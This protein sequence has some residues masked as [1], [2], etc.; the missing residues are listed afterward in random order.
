MLEIKGLRLPKRV[1]ATQG[2]EKAKI[3]ITLYGSSLHTAG[4]GTEEGIVNEG[5]PPRVR[6]LCPQYVA[7]MAASCT[8]DRGG[9]LGLL[10]QEAGRGE[11]DGG[12][13]SQSEPKAA[14]DDGAS[15]P[16]P[17][18]AKPPAF[19][20]PAVPQKP[21]E[22]AGQKGRQEER[23]LVLPAHRRGVGSTRSMP[24]A[25]AGNRVTRELE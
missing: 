19:Q 4:F 21:Q 24:S 11:G 9:S 22:K 18:A 25:E 13:G 6:T 23:R 1:T 8:R 2:G 16:A 20:R 7:P 17:A 14:E 15:L 3:T 12:D 10:T 5:L